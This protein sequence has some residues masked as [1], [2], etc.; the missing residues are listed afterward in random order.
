VAEGVAAAGKA[1]FAMSALCGMPL[2]ALRQVVVTAYL[3]GENHAATSVLYTHHTLL[4]LS[5]NICCRPTAVVVIDCLR[6]K[7]RLI[8]RIAFAR[9]IPPTA[10]HFH[11]A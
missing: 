4:R 9:A 6:N 10:T 1:S 3:A 7:Q 5:A 11:V 8:R 2:A